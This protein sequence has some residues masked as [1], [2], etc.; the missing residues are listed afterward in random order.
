MGTQEKLK[1]I[2]FHN[3]KEFLQ[4]SQIYLLSGL[5]KSQCKNTIFVFE[6]EFLCSKANY[7]EFKISISQTL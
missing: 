2:I 4:V 1:L 5:N 6:I 7:K 3:K